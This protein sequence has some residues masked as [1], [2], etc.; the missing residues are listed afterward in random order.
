MNTVAAA[1]DIA[2][3]LERAPECD[4]SRMEGVRTSQITPAHLDED[5]GQ[6]SRADVG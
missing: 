6:L 5:R 1:S 2:L 3:L 4:V